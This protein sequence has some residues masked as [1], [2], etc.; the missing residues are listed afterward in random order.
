MKKTLLLLTASTTVSHAAITVIHHY[1]LDS[2][3][4]AGTDS[5]GAL[6]LTAT[7]ST[8][9][10]AG[11]V[12]NGQLFSG[13]AANDGGGAHENTATNYLDGGTTPTVGTSWGVEMW[14]RPDVLPDG[15]NQ[16]EVGLIH[17]GGTSNGLALE[18]S[19]NAG[20][21]TWAVHRPGSSFTHFG[22]PTVG[23]WTHLA[24][25]NDNGTAQLYIDGV[26]AGSAG[27]A[28]LG[29]GAPDLTLGSMWADNR[30][31]FNGAMD[32]VRIFTFSTGQFDINDTLHA[33]PEPSSTA[34]LGL[35]GLALILRRRK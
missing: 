28:G 33:V 4:S 11:K 34:L 24:Y 12:G 23:L 1:N 5:A 19:Y 15:T 14:V 31:G 13:N 20:A 6:N 25:V 7:G 32:E 17:M 9:D 8:T 16:T 27:G 21:A 26:S 35:G 29:A 18:M 2:A 3:A 10:V 22:A 30:R